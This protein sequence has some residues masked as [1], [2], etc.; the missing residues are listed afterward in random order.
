MICD[1]MSRHTG[2][3]R[4]RWHSD[5]TCHKNKNWTGMDWTPGSEQLRRGVLVKI[6]AIWPASELVL[7]VIFITAFI[8]WLAF[9]APMRKCLSTCQ[10]GCSADEEERLWATILNRILP[11]HFYFFKPQRR[12]LLKSHELRFNVLNPFASPATFHLFLHPSLT[13]PGLLG[14]LWSTCPFKMKTNKAYF[15]GV[16]VELMDELP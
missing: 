2:H 16:V 11:F 15:N 12:F 3:V 9:T 14:L 5:Q 8:A 6:S 10:C 4:K 7:G 13:A 1:L